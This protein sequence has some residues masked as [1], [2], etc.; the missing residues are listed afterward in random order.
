MLPS[1]KS[2]NQQ[3]FHLKKAEEDS[4]ALWRE[5][6]IA[7]NNWKSDEVFRRQPVEP[8]S[9]A[10]KLTGR[11]QVGDGSEFDCEVNEISPLGLGISGPKE[12]HVGQWCTAN[13]ASVG[14]VE[15]IVIHAELGSLTIGI[16]GLPSRIRRLGRRFRWLL[17]Q[18]AEP[19]EDRRS[20]E[21]I[22]MKHAAATIKTS[23]GRIFPCQI[24]DLSEGGAALHLGSNSLY[25][26]ADQP[27]TMDDRP[28]HVLRIFP[29]GF[30]IKFD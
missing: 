5:V 18:E 20:S 10:L 24:F 7:E 16:I 11:Y 1:E 13:V 14:I 8:E 17:Q 27:V 21:R 26:W 15:G 30:V 25:F 28:G 2:A 19:V 3:T 22:E 29:G 4:L 6:I 9:I 12:G 23:E